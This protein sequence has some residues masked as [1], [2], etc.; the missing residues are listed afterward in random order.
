MLL[1]PALV[2]AYF[3][4]H[5]PDPLRVE[6]STHECDDTTDPMRYVTANFYSRYL[7]PQIVS[8]ILAFLS[9]KQ[10]VLCTMKDPFFI[11]MNEYI[12]EP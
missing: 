8:L 9:F 3:P 6:H 10:K 11:Y 12:I 2:A 4:Q 7:A 1:N 5:S